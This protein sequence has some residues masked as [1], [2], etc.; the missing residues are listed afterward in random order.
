M[1]TWKRVLFT[2]L[3][4]L[5]LTTMVT[6]AQAEDKGTL[7]IINLTQS[8][9]VLKLD[10]PSDQTV[11][12][13]KPFTKVSLEF[14]KYDYSYRACGIRRTGTFTLGFGGKTIKLVKCEKGLY[15][16]LII[17][18][19]TGKTFDLLLNGPKV[20]ML[21]VIP[22]DYKYT[23]QAGRYSYRALVCGETRTGEKGLKSK[24]NADWVWSCKVTK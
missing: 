21:S 17:S 11:T 13:D 24:N 10:G 4:A 8:T 12:I 14:G 2:G 3:A 18:N 19:L 7:T 5:L 16:T 15:A 22:G 9:V 6:P 1:K 23:V 20:Y